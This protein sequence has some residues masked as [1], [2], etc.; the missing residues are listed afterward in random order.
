[1][2]RAGGINILLCN[3]ASARPCCGGPTSPRRHP[4]PPNRRQFYF[5]PLTHPWNAR[6]RAE[7]GLRVCSNWLHYFSPPPI[8]GS[9]NSSRFRDTIEHCSIGII[10]YADTRVL[11]NYYTSHMIYEIIRPDRRNDI[12]RVRLPNLYNIIYNFICISLYIPIY[13]Y[14]YIYK[15]SNRYFVC[16]AVIFLFRGR[17]GWAFVLPPCCCY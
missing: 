9:N 11:F 8:L 2:S 12:I 14:I 4:P 10:I 16:S 5:P 15:S 6:A 17:A 13:I 3:S 7:V 1:M